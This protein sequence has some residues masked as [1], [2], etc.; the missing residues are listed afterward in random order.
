[1]LYS[2]LKGTFKSKALEQGENFS[3][4]ILDEA[5]RITPTD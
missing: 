5:H 2:L 4:V 1:M 3:C